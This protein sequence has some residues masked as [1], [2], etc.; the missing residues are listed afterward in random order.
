MAWSN[1]AATAVAMKAAGWRS[2]VVGG[3]HCHQLP[4][5]PGSRP[6]DRGQP[7]TRV[8]LQ[9]PR[10]QTKQLLPDIAWFSIDIIA[11]YVQTT[12]Y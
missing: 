7:W 1:L 5:G 3:H 11:S 9:P 4:A 6:V 2:C 10:K 12:F 8:N